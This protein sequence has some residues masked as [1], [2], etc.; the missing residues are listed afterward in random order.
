[1]KAKVSRLF[2]LDGVDDVEGGGACDG[3]VSGFVSGDG[4]G[5]GDYFVEV[6][7][8]RFDVEEKSLG[9]RKEKTRSREKQSR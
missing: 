2:L 8:T 3:I 4:A 1:M 6:G 9:V 5:A 7:E